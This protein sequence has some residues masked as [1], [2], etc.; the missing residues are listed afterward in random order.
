LFGRSSSG[1]SPLLIVELGSGGLSPVLALDQTTGSC[2]I[3][4]VLALALNTGLLIA[5]SAG[6]AT[7]FAT[8]SLPP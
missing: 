1:G 4:T 7:L 8:S 5:R 3:P 2:Q 6:P